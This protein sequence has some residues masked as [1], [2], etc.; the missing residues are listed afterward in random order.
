MSTEKEHIEQLITRNL[1]AE[2]SHKEFEELAR[3]IGQSYENLNRFME[4]KNVWDA[5]HPAFDLQGV[6]PDDALKKVQS[7]IAQARRQRL[8]RKLLDGWR[9]IAA[10][11]AIPLLVST[12][13]FSMRGERGADA[14]HYQEVTAL[15][16]TRTRIVLPDSS[17]AWLNGGSNMRYPSAFTDGARMIEMEGEAYFQV[18]ADEQYPFVVRTARMDVVATGTEFNVEAFADE[19]QTAVTLTKGA[20]SVNIAGKQANMAPNERLVYEHATEQYRVFKGDTYKWCS[21]KDGVLAFRNDPLSYVFKRLG[22]VHNIEFIVDPS[23]EKHIYYATFENESLD[24]ILSL[25]EKS[26]PIRCRI[27][28]D[29]ENR[30]DYR[31]KQRIEVLK[32]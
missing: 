30:A 8:G 7:R 10:V 23:I 13:W 25:L 21:W 1:S 5:A 16:G 11:I 6:H 12:I 24:R 17:V 27:L 14:P 9:W 22:Q 18:S 32:R 28:S 4:L 29:N 2:A 31:E 19:N 26:A 3:W 15:Y 20:V